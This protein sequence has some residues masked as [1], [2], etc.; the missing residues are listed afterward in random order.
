MAQSDAA[1]GSRGINAFIVE[2]GMEGFTLGAK[3][4]KM[5][6]RASDTR[7]LQF[8]NVKVPRENLLGEDGSGFRFAMETLE[9]GRLGI[10]AQALGIASGAFEL[11]VDYSKERQSFGRPIADHQ[12]ISFKLA[13]MATGIEAARLLCLKAAWLK[14]HGKPYG[15]ASAM[16][17]L[18][19]SEVAMN[20]TIEAVQIHGGYGYVKEYHVERLMRDA[21]ITQIYEGTSEVQ[22]I[23]I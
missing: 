4:E 3:E 20:G 19:A 16:A 12:A 7:S 6:I 23:V 2:K 15:H 5:G 18:Y 14:D 1:K 22:R 8:T 21:K 13:D 10:A 17:K 9:G 11:A